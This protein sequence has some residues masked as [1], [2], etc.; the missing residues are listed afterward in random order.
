MGW[1]QGLLTK[2]NE[3]VGPVAE[4]ME[5]RLL[6]SA[7]LAGA[8]TLAAAMDA[9]AEHRT[10]APDGEY[11]QPNAVER[12]AL[13]AN[14]VVFVDMGVPDADRLL[15]DLQDQRDAGRLIDIVRIEAGDDGI[16]LIS[17][18]LAARS[19]ITAV[20]ILSHGTEG[21]IQLGGAWL[22][23]AALSARGG[24]I[25]GWRAA[26]GLDADLL[27]YGCE[28][29]GSAT[30][31]RLLAD[32]GALTGADVAGST[33]VT[34]A[35]RS[36]GDW[37]LEASTG[38]IDAVGAIS[39]GAQAEWQ[40][41]LATYTVSTTLDVTLVPGTLRW[42]IQQANSNP[43]ADTI[44]LP[45]GNFAVALPGG[46]DTGLLGDL[47]INGD[48]TIQGNGSGN[49][50]VQGNGLD[51][52]F[53]VRSGDVD[54]KDLTISGGGSVSKGGGIHVFAAGSTVTL[55]R[56][57]VEG[58][59]AN[60][61]AGIFSSGTLILRD[62]HLDANVGTGSNSTGG[63]LQNEG[64]ATV[65]RTTV[66]GNQA[67]DGGGIYSKN[68][69]ITIENSTIS[70]NTASSAG[71][72]LYTKF[73]GN[74]IIS[75]T[76]AFNTAPV[77]GG[78][79]ADAAGSF[80][81]KGTILADN[82]GGNANAAQQSMGH[83]IDTDN[84]AGLLQATDLHPASAG[85]ASLADNGGFAPTHALLAGSVARDAGA[86]DAPATDQ[87]GEARSGA[88]DIGSF[89]FANAAP[90]IS[91]I[92][93]QTTPEDTPAAVINFTVGDAETA[94]AALV[95][96]VTSGNAAVLA[97]AGMVLGG[98]GAN[99]TLTLTPV[100]NGRGLATVT[101]TV[102]DG[103]RSSSTT[104]TLTVTSVN[105]PPQGTD[106]TIA[107]NEDAPRVLTVADFGFSDTADGDALGAVRITSLAGGGTLAGDGVAVTAGSVVSA[108][109]IASGKL[110][111]TPAPDANG[112]AY[113]SFGFK[114]VDTGG[115]ADAGVDEDPTA[116]L[117][118][119]NVTP[120]ADLPVTSDVA[121][122]P[123]AEDSGGLLI[124]TAQLLANAADG[125]GTPVSLSGVTL[126]SGAA[127]GTF[128][129]HGDG[130]W[131]FTPAANFNGTVTFGY[132]ITSGGDTIAGSASLVVTPVAD[133]PTTSNV[134]LGP[135][136]EDS[137]GVLVTRAQLLGN[138]A[139]GD[140]T[141]LILSGVTLT[142]GAASGTLLDNGN[143]TWT[144][145]PAANF[146]GTATLGYAITSGG[147]TIAGTAS[148]V[149]TA[150]SD[151]P[152]HTVPGPLTVA[153]DTLLAIGGIS[154][155]DPDGDLTTT[156]VRVSNGNLTVD[157]SGGAT[158]VA[159]G[160]GRGSLT[161]AGTQAQINAAL[162]TLQYLGDQDYFGPDT[163]T[164]RSADGP[165]RPTV[166]R[167]AITVTPVG[168]DLPTTSNVAL[169]SVAEDSGA[170]LVTA[171]QL[172][173]NAADPDGTPLTV[174]AVSITSGS[175]TLVDNGNGTWTFT[176]AANFNGTVS[177][178]YSVT[179]GSDTIAGTA[180]LDVTPVADLPATSDVTLGPV[181]EDSGALLITTAQLLANASDGDGTPL[182]LSGV[183]ITSAA[184]SGTLT[185]NGDGTWTFTPAA[186]F[187]GA[188]TFGYSITSGGDTIAGSASLVVTP[189]AD[190]PATSNVVLGPVT[191][192]SGALSITT[193]QLLGN[194]VDEDGTPL[195]L[196]G[197][198]I[199]SGAG[200]GTLTDNGDGT[201]TF[202]PAA[203]FNGTVTFGYSI[204][205]GGDT[206]AGTASLDV[207]PVADLPTTSNVT[208]GPVAEDSGALLITTAQLLANASDGDGTP[209]TLSGV[210]VTSAAG[211]GTLTD[212]G[213]G[214]WTFTPAANFN[215]TVTFGY[216]VTSGGDTIVG[217]AS[218]VVT[219]V[220][221]LPT[222]S[223]VVLNPVAEDS[224]ALV[225]T[226]A[227]LLANAADGDGTALTVGAVSVT[228]GSGTLVNNGNG[229]W[230][231]TPA[232][233]FNGTV[234]FNYNV[235]SGGDMVAGT[236]T[237]AV[238]PVA[239][240][241]TTSNVTL[242][243]VAE[244]SGALLITTA[245]LLGN[246]AD[247]DGT[248]LTLSGVTVT[249]AA[250]S[251]TLTDNG[252]GTWTFTPAANFNGTV[253]F[254]YSIT[255]GGDTI[256]G[257]AS[258]VVTP[259]A[260]LPMTSNVVLGPVAEDSG[261]LLITAAQLLANAA[262]GDGT[263]LTVGAVSVTPG[264]GTLVNNGNGTWTFTPAAN[265]NGTV[266]FNYNVRS[267]GDM[268]AGTATLAVTPVA[269]LPTTSN[270][271]LGSVAED[272]GALLIT[273]AQL[274]AN[275]SDGDGT[276][277]T[278]SGVT[279]TSAAG[280]GTLTDNGNGTWT[281]TPAAN[282]NGA[283]TFGYSITSGGDTI[284]GTA[285]LAVP[286]VNDVPTTSEVTLGPVLED[287]GALVIT[288]AQLLANAGDADGS[289][290]TATNLAVTSGNGTLVN[291]GN[292]TWTFRPAAN[293]DGAV[294]FSYSIS[295]GTAAVSGTAS[296]QVTPVNDAPAPRRDTVDAT[297]DTAVTFTPA[298]LLGND[299]DADG[300]SLTIAGVTSGAG[301]TAVLNPDGSIT[302][303]PATNFSGV[304]T[305]TYTVTDGI[306]TSAPV[307]VTVNVASVNDA[308]VAQDDLL[309]GVEDTGITWSPADLLGNDR[310]I[311]GDALT[312]SSVTSA[313]GGTAVLNADG[314]V[315]FVPDANFNGD[316]TFTYTVGDDT[317]RSRTASV[318]VRVAPVADAP[319]LVMN[320]DMP[321][322]EGQTS[323]GRIGATDVDSPGETLRFSIAGGADGGRFVIDAVTGQLIFRAGPD[324]DAPGDADGDNV[325][326]VAV[327][328]SDG[329]LATTQTFT[330]RVQDVVETPTPPPPPPTPEP[331]PPPPPP[332]PGPPA[333]PPPPPPPPP[334]P[335][336][337]I[338]GQPPGD[339]PGLPPPP[340]PPTFTVS[341]LP[342]L[343]V[344]PLP[345]IS[346][347]GPN[348]VRTVVFD[349]DGMLLAS[350]DAP[351]MSVSGFG[352]SA[353]VEAT[354]MEDLQRSLRSGSFADNLNRLREEVR[355]N[356]SLEQSF[357][358]SVAGVS[359]GLS[360]VYVLWLIRGGVL[361]GSYLSALPAWR[362]LDPLPVLARRGEDEE[363]DEEDM[364]GALDT[365]RNVLRG[366]G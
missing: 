143:G 235:R 300:D 52:V 3:R 307:T 252:N 231:F 101:V 313:S 117:L 131:T 161:L 296:L 130:T 333:P 291:N 99:R 243:P 139:D 81:F 102:S 199:T 201:W 9:P 241:P 312:I 290:M 151:D 157:L 275:A 249:S 116:N 158:I 60:A 192:D 55:D 279:L 328:V 26:L 174:S 68:G 358:V 145:T 79:Y 92:A 153:E 236:A 247:A 227:Q 138:A 345:E 225:I 74:Q 339:G 271:T 36:G 341:P 118:T 297:E 257:T 66:S 272:S 162:A 40:G 35:Q 208:L 134:V 90:T 232:A 298:Q 91:V 263:A 87:R 260:D 188:V 230:T 224:G 336:P 154:V 84:S 250:G 197:V 301:G 334:G 171:A 114:V 311:D 135:V 140:G 56:V 12:V 269:D 349:R 111:F 337:V 152:V 17:D 295:D 289:A 310:D 344:S 213:N 33:D 343:T 189:V 113:A 70:G 342:T 293:F 218:L 63:G 330:V 11:V 280:S 323:V 234:T 273:T 149:V 259:V 120:V 181:A 326:T 127:S 267:G 270:V 221:D 193:T 184:G 77:G 175:G 302:F 44:V 45:S 287:S 180:S 23:A 294:T 42:A 14:E 5:P 357:S 172:L 136:A 108:A 216:S 133:L 281:F 261:A 254:G 251:G 115:T 362:I 318:T 124:T 22:D 288:A 284:A 6:Y 340:A 48:V 242:G 69:P 94:A 73:G 304:A 325:Y 278:L 8:F 13:P 173:A 160:N 274:L 353:R 319:V 89:E 16:A 282:F 338:V 190:L 71:G 93:D 38:R 347:V 219:S 125:D 95:V 305:F 110:V 266:T 286:P 168:D 137:G 179:S 248:P 320:P 170:L 163:L 10:L 283:V 317:A 217:T 207:M 34:G 308:P 246:A 187:N 233:N 141:P 324:Y 335:P 169:G 109:D 25:A 104:F 39:S 228:P 352:V 277:L 166:D 256:V 46:D 363:A 209:L 240:L 366:F 303:R 332:P 194:A 31:E 206:I 62:V 285:S 292:G 80:I 203:N 350:V 15:Q 2:K 198:S 183:T 67:V 200:S 107:I 316:A 28:V 191:E 177:F 264:S 239:D 29:A 88:A 100:T 105:D 210:T 148:L 253:T 156:R 65:L 348:A 76:I 202:T 360:L 59:R 146:S 19:G 361:M 364:E 159:G 50:I 220:A 265:F 306:T 4:P 53:D 21:R 176:P 365:G 75:S 214:T 245:Q 112:N 98:S 51:R 83:N 86:A 238:T 47:D 150:L 142:S 346:S 223:N 126:T 276:P 164:V 132:S 96:T 54:F 329:V 155:D 321:V 185:D 255:S 147:D 356:V 49:T 354:Q 195:T 262:D 315:T 237:L 215:G 211:S 1:L 57:V 268:V 178:G 186:N 322:L 299:T 205:S 222:T 58:N 314:S 43:G 196:S 182:T 85:I 106:N 167:V 359:L 128:V 7:D 244:D 30:G 20:H 64:T 309:Q 229:T 123:V 78:V 119:F 331:P 72:G 122:G 144:F 355:E 327:Q 121:L 32:L 27:L 165:G 226:A 41:L 97:S 212:N 204:T 82:T 37:L 103:S 24:E 129:D 18:T 258:L 351:G 61:G